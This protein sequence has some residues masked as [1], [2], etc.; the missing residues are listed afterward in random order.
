MKKAAGFLALLLAFFL[1]TWLAWWMVPAVALLWGGLRPAVNRP[2]GTAAVAAGAAWAVWLVVDAVAGGGALATL[3]SRLS[4]VLHLPS[5]AL[6]AVTVLFPALLA[7]SATAL[8]GGTAE[9]FAP[10][11]GDTR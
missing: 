5:Y 2:A 8:A 10:R 7:W 9:L 3:V 4:G 1:A 6:F 11:S